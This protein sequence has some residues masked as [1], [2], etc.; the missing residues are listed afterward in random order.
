MA[1]ESTDISLQDKLSIYSRWLENGK[2]VEHFLGIIRCHKVNAE[3]LAGS[4][5]H[6]MEG[7]ERNPSPKVAWI[8]V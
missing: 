3:E 6:F 1:D 4:L 8:R 5:L 2:P 7:G